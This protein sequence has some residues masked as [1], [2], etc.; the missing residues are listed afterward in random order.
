MEEER[1]GTS[2]EWIVAWCNWAFSRKRGKLAQFIIRHLRIGDY[3]R[4]LEAKKG[5]FEIRDWQ[6]LAKIWYLE[7]ERTSEE[8]DATSIFKKGLSK[9]FPNLQEVKHL[10]VK[11]GTLYKT[12]VFEAPK[13]LCDEVYKFVK[14]PRTPA[15]PL[16]C[17]TV[18]YPGTSNASLLEHY[19]YQSNQ[20]TSMFPIG[21]NNNQ[22]F[23]V[24]FP[25]ITTKREPTFQ[26]STHP[27]TIHHSVPINQYQQPQIPLRIFQRPVPHQIL[28][29]HTTYVTQPE[30]TIQSIPQQLTS[31]LP[32]NTIYTL[33]DPVR[34]FSV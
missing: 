20:Y 19:Q 28:N 34:Q 7:K 15:I 32:G 2:D 16:E 31:M 21:P 3:A 14:N 9:A 17:T 22:V 4:W 10:S 24:G 18:L 1:P 12:R 8:M 23:D 26:Q 30:Y 33:R 25:H 6:T 13:E 29:Q 11:E 5:K 27:T